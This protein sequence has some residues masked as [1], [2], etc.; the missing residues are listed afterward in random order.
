MYIGAVVYSAAVYVFHEQYLCMWMYD[1][2]RAGVGLRSVNGC[3]CVHCTRQL[4]FTVTA[5]LT[6]ATD[7]HIHTQRTLLHAFRMPRLFEL[8]LLACVI[9]ARM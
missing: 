6:K 4:V 9:F 1:R 2:G 7:V 3:K 5:A 8:L